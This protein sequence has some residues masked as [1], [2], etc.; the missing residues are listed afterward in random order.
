MAAKVRID[1]QRI[2]AQGGARK[3]KGG[4]GRPRHFVTACSDH[5][6]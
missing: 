1:I 6:E 3:K 4:L 5:S 2:V